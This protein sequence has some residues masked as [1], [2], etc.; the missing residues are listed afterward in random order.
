MHRSQNPK[1]VW[2]KPGVTGCDWV[3]TGWPGSKFDIFNPRHGSPSYGLVWSAFYIL[4]P[5]ENLRLTKIIRDHFRW[6]SFTTGH[7]KFI[8]LGARK[9]MNAQSSRNFLWVENYVHYT[10]LYY[11]VFTM[12]L[13]CFKCQIQTWQTGWSSVVQKQLSRCLEKRH[14]I[15]SAN[16]WQT[17]ALDRCHCWFGNSNSQV[18]SCHQ[19]LAGDVLRVAL[20][21]L[22]LLHCPLISCLKVGRILEST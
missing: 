9:I 20:S 21:A 6:Y 13:P 14:P 10:S 19:S 3:V 1:N 8:V 15:F 2:V 4:L 12:Y 22:P 11:T 5:L 17:Q 18:V 7:V 16:S